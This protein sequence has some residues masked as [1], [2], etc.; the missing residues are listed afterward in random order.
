LELREG[1]SQ[2]KV[3]AALAV[4]YVVWGSTYL[5]ILYAID[6]IPVFLS[7]GIRFVLAG[8][9]LYAWA[10][11]RGDVLGDRIGWRQWAAAVLVGGL[12]F[13]G[14]NSLVAWSE[15]R[16]DTG[17]AAL[18][19]AAV[20]LWM[21]LFDRAAN[22]Q[23]LSRS[24]LIGLLVG[25]AGVAL[26]AWP[27]GPS[28]INALG[29][30]ALL[31]SGAAWAAG[32]L[33]ARGSPLPRRPLVSSGMQML[34]GGMLLMLVAGA[35]GELTEVGHVSL[36]SVLAMVYLIVFGSWLA[37]STY[38]WLLQVA[39]TSVVS[40]YAYVNPVVAVFLGWVVLSEPLSVRT[41]VAGAVILGAVALIVT[42]ARRRPSPSPAS[43]PARAQ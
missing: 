8:G 27:S 39:P 14:G 2:A 35:S 22:G 9:L 26:L 4:V 33:I 24:T 42:P 34:A 3:W 41:V 17:V 7:M 18:L 40:T 10:V 12:L 13:V 30:V 28:R 29:A 11:R 25:F 23:R 5:G 31:V 43:V 15:T 1:T 38:S 21:A 36:R 6:T 20:P 19:I 37:F 16:V 32:S